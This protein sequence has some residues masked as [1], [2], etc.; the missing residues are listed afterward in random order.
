MFGV[1]SEEALCT[2]QFRRCTCIQLHA[3]MQGVSSITWTLLKHYLFIT[4]TPSS[5]FVFEANSDR[6]EV[7]II[8]RKI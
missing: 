3:I 5:M 2:I 7:A 6:A 8:Y 4:D 1:S